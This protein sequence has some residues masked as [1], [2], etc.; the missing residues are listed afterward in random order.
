MNHK[1]G[2]VTAGDGNVATAAKTDAVDCSCVRRKL[3]ATV[4]ALI[5]LGEVGKVSVR[6]TAARSKP[7]SS[8]QT[9][10]SVT[11][12]PY[13]GKIEGAAAV[14]AAGKNVLSDGVEGGTGYSACICH[15][16]RPTFR[17]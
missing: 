14:F 4:A 10:D 6:R 2:V 5:V 15:L 9:R 12:D 11:D 13:L 1:G 16:E 17:G 8:I 7:F 3:K